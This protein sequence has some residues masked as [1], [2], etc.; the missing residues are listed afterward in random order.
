LDLIAA[1]EAH[2]AAAAPSNGTEC[3]S[4]R[5]EVARF[6]RRLRLDNALVPERPKVDARIR[7]RRPKFGAPRR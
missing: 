6:S 7:E 2:A 1:A 3:G 5:L 4:A